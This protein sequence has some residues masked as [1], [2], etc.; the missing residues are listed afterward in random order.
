[1]V[2][3]HPDP[4]NR[5]SGFPY[6]NMW[7]F[8]REV[9]FPYKTFKLRLII[10]LVLIATIYFGFILARREKTISGFV[11]DC[12]TNKPIDNT[13]VFV[14]QRGWGFDRY[15][16]WD[17]S[18]VYVGKSDNLGYF[19][20]S[21]KV[22]NSANI[23]AKKEGYITAQQFEKPKDGVILKMLR[24][25]KPLE[26]TYKCRLS[27]ECLQTTIENNVQVTRNICL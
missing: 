17:K 13:E 12:Q 2:R 16:I 24:G 6:N 3:F 21:Y 23:S 25:S 26:V 20:I 1:M 4:Q 18:Y 7:G 14:N 27:S 19:K 9:L 11:L 5:F 10:L 15:L 8:I 22:G